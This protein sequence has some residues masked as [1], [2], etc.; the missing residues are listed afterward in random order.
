M[1]GQGSGVE[2]WEFRVGGEG[3]GS[4]AKGWRSGVKGQ[5]LQWGAKTDG[6]GPLS[7]PKCRGPALPDRARYP[8]PVT[9]PLT[10]NPKPPI[11]GYL[12]HKKQRPPSTL[13]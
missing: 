6:G 9:P 13:E 10:L 8:W 11:Q 7:I 5:G 12:A 1:K 4:W 3:R 2:G